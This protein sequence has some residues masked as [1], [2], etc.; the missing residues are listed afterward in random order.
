MQWNRDENGNPVSW[1]IPLETQQISPTHGV[2]QLVQVPDQHYRMTIVTEDNMQLTEVFNVQDIVE[3]SFYVDYGVGIVQFHKSQHGKMVKA[4]YYGRGVILI[5]D[6]RIFHRDGE[7]VTDTWDNILDR[8]QDALDLI[9]SAGGLVQALEKID[10]KIEQGEATAD[11]I[12]N[13]ITETQFYGYTITLS[14]EAFVVKAKEDGDV[15]KMEIQSIFTDVVVYKGAKQIIPVLSIEQENGCVFKIDGQ[16]VKLSSID[17]NVIKAGAVLN[18]DCGDGLVAKRVL[19]VTKVFDGVSQYAIDMSNAFYSFE[20]NNAGEIT[21]SQSVTCAITVTKA[22][23]DYTNYKLGVQNAPVG[24]KYTIGATGVEFCVDKGAT[25]PSSGSCL[26]VVL[27]DGTSFTKTFS[28]TKTK[29]GQDAKSLTLIGN[30]IVRYDTPDYSDI[31]SPYRSTITA[32][33]VGL[34]GTPKW[35]VKRESGWVLLEGE[36]QTELQIV[37]N[38]ERVWGNHKETTVKCSLEDYEDELTLVKLATGGNG[39]DAIT[40]ILTNESHTLAIDNSGVVHQSEIDRT[41][42]YVLAYKGAQQVAPVLT[43]GVCD[44]CDIEITD[45][46]VQLVSLDNSATTA[47]AIINVAVDGIIVPKTWSLAKAKQGHDGADGES[48]N[49]YILNVTEGTRSF[50]YSQVNLDPRPAISSTFVATLYENGAEVIEDVSYYWTARGHLQGSSVTKTF[51]PTITRTFDESIT[52]NDIQLIATYK[53]NTITQLVPIAVTKDASGLDWVQEWDSTKTDVRGNLILTP[54]IFAGAYD[55]ENDLITG[56]AI[57]QDVLND[58]RSIGVVGYQSNKPSFVLD[59]DGSLMVGNPFEKD[60]TGLYYDNGELIAK[61]HSLTIQGAEVPTTDAITS[62]VDEKLNS[63]KEG[64]LQE[65]EDVVGQVGELGAYMDGALKDGILDEVER[66]RLNTLFDN[67]GLEVNDVDAQFVSISQNP[68]LTNVAL[69][70]QLTEAY[71]A[72]TNKYEEMEVAFN[73]IIGSSTVDVEKV[74]TFNVLMEEFVELGK[75]LR[76]IM[77]DALSS[78]STSISE[79]IAEQA[80]E[81]I[82]S[83]ISDV[84]DALGSLEDTMNGDFKSGLISTMN[85]TTLRSKVSQLETEK[86]DIDGQYRGIVN[87]PKLG[88]VSRT[89]L[90]N[91]KGELDTAHDQLIIKINTAIADNLMTEAELTEINTLITKYATALNKYSEI[92]QQANAD[93]ALNLAQGA[94]AALNQEDVF[95]KLTNNGET[96]GIYLQDGK[97][98]INGEYIN[99]RNFKAVR[100]DGTQTMKIDS[101]GNVH[102]KA[103]SFHLIGDDTNVS[104]KEYVD[105]EIGKIALGNV[106]IVLSNEAQVISTNANSVPLAN[107]SFAIKVQMYKGTSEVTDFSIGTVAS[108]NGITSTV[109]QSTKTVTFSVSSTT[110]IS[111][112]SGKIT[113]PLTYEGKTYNKDWSWAIAKQ[114]A[115]GATG[116]AGTS[117]KSVDIVASSMV[118]KSADGGTTFSPNAITLTPKLQNLTYS[119]W[120]YSTNGGTS[121]STVSSGSNGLTISGGVLTISKDSSLYT[122]S[123]TSVSFRVN[124]N[125]SAYYDVV[126]IVKLYDVAELEVTAVNRALGTGT[127]ATWNITSGTNKTWTP[128]T[129]A[130]NVRSK[131]VIVAFDYEATNIVKNADYETQFQAYYV[132]S[133]GSNVYAPSYKFVLPDGDSSGTIV[134]SVLNFG[135]IKVGNKPQFRFRFDNVAGTFKISKARVIIGSRDTGWSLAPE[136]VEASISDVSNALSSFENTVNGSFKDGIIEEAEAKAISQN[137]NILNNEKADID[138]EYSSIYDNANLTGTPKTNLNSAY[139]SFISAHSSLIS[140]INTAIFDGKTTAAEKASVNSTFTTYKGVLATYKQRVQEALDAI[141]SKK[142]ENVQVGGRNL[143][144]KGSVAR[145]SASSTNTTITDEDFVKNGSV[146]I[147]RTAVTN[148]GAMIDRYVV[149]EAGKEYC[150]SYKMKTISGAINSV[151]IYNGAGHKNGKVYIDGVYKG[152]TGVDLTYPSDT[153]YHNILI[154]FTAVAVSESTANGQNTTHIIPQPI[155]STASAYT[156]QYLNLK[157]EQGNKPT[158]W[159]P[160]PEDVSQEIADKVEDY[161][162]SLNQLKVF[163]KL[164]NNGQTQGVYLENG[165]V[166]INGEYIKASSISGNKISAGVIT[167]KNGKSSINLDNGAMSLGSTSDTSYLQWTGSDL[168]IKAKNISIGSSSVATSSDVTS[169]VNTAVNNIQVGGTNLA[170]DTNKGATGWGWGIQTNNGKTITGETINGVNCVKFTKD[171]TSGSGWNYVNYGRFKRDK[172]TPSTTYVVSFEMKSN[173]SFNVGSVNLMNGDS[174]NSLVKTIT[175]I[176]NKVVANSTTWNKIIFELT[177]TDTLSTSTAQVIYITGIPCS[178]NATHY[179]RNLKLEVGNKATQWSPAPEDIDSS[180]QGAITTSKEYTNSQIKSTKDAIELSV[181]NTYETKTNVS[182]QISSTL[183]SAKSYADTK[184]S[185]AI[186]T[187]SSDATS[188]ANSALSSAKSYTDTAKNDLNTAIGKKANSADVYTKTEVYTKSQTDSAIK[189]AKDAIDLSVKS[190]DTKVTNITNTVNNIQIGTENLLQNSN[191]YNSLSNWTTQTYGTAGTDLSVTIV[192]GG[193]WTDSNYNHVQIRGTNHVD[194]Y[195]IHSSAFKVVKGQKYTVSG[196]AAG[197]RVGKIRVTI[198]KSSDGV[199]VHNYEIPVVTGGNSIDK[200]KYFTTT[201]TA[202][203]DTDTILFCFYGENLQDNGYVWGTLFK[204]E[205]GTKA[206]DWTQSSKDITTDITKAKNDAIASANGTLTT[207]IKNYYTKTETDSQIKIAKDSINLGVSQTYET[208]TNVSSQINNTLSSAKSYADTK[209]SEAISSASSDATTK[210]NNALS[211]AK[212]YADTKKTEAI[213][214]ANNTLNTTIAN[215]YTKSQTDSQINV[216]KN[217]ITQSVSNTYETKTNV[218]NKIDAIKIGG[219]NLLGGTGTAKVRNVD[220]PT[221]YDVYDTYFTDGNKTTLRALGFKVNDELSVSFDWKISKNGSLNMVYGN[222]R[223]ELMG[224]NSSNTDG[225]Y[226]GLIKNPVA[227]FSSSNTSGRFEGT[228]KLTE[229]MLGAYCLRIRTDNSVL[230]ITI[231]NAK[232]EKGNKVSS[233]S[234]SPK[235]METTVSNL[236]QRVSTAESKI[237]DTAITNVVKQNFYTKTE[238]DNQIT[239]KGYQT[240]SQVQQTVNNLQLKFTQSGGYNLFSNSGFKKGTSYWSTHTHNSPTGGSIETL[241]SSATWGFPDSTVNCV[242]IKLSNQS[243]KEYG[244]TQT[245]KTTIGKKYTLSFYYAGHRLNQ[246]NAI[247]RNSN[248]SWLANKYVNTLP[249]G[250]NTNV[251]NWN[252]YTLTFTANATSHNINIV[253]VSAANDGYLWVAK[254]MVVEGELDLPYSPNPNE[255]YDGI[256][257]MNRDGI[258]VSTSNGGWTDFTSAGMNVYNKAGNLSLGTRNGGLTYHNKKGYIGFTSESVVNAYDVAGVTISTA[259]NG[260][261]IT[262]GTSTTTDPF[263]GFT[264]TP[265]LSI[266]KADIGDANTSFYHQGV[267]LHTT[268]NVNTKPIKQVGTMYYGINGMTRTYESTTGNLCLLGDNG[269]V[270]GYYQGNDI[271]TKFKIIEGSSASESYIDTYAHWRFHGW[272][273]T[274]VANLSIKNNIKMETTATIQFN[275]T[276]TYP[277]LMW[278]A[279]NRL[280]LYGN[281]GIDFGY[282]NGSSNMPIFKLHE[283]ADTA[284][285]IESFSHWNFNNWNLENV[286]ILKPQRLQLP[287]TYGSN[288]IGLGTGDGNDY[289]TYNVKFR[290]HNGLAFTDNSDSATVIVQ[291]RQGR[292]MGK[293]AYYVNCSRSLKSD[294]RSV[295]SE[296]DVTTFVAKEGESLDTNISAETVC[297]FLDAIGVKT[298]VTDFKQEGAT[299]ECFDIEKGNSL[300]LGYVADDIAD[301]PMFKYVGEKTNDGLYAINSNSLT[302]TLIVG[303]QQEKRKREQLEERLARLEQ[304]LK[305]DE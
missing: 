94:I 51:T 193:D 200:Y 301:H 174:S 187:A 78:I 16:R 264:S 162:N 64:L 248:G 55:A 125:D 163:N 36:H 175:A 204:I 167:A 179:I 218:Q 103:N 73:E 305:G 59:T 46:F 267:N 116:S 152:T 257:E 124:T 223:A 5:S 29:R 286:G 202:P 150:I 87:N 81:E 278:E 297:D 198:R 143:A 282:R 138:K 273:L 12:E 92:A 135:D 62:V 303:Y 85:L 281:D 232:W 272:S 265:A 171:S 8:S 250:G 107:Q 195:G 155:K 86:A 288:W 74:G 108:A 210:A 159:S 247:V 72:Y 192:K 67:I 220:K 246:I 112:V 158:G 235:D 304:L 133:S 169:T 280:K 44:G 28:W 120:Q 180:V 11:R 37:H 91:A 188:K 256:V 205:K 276:A 266:A 217:A 201:F 24:L 140:T 65:F 18:I 22:N 54:K 84:S 111:A 160:A 189:V 275:S 57:G 148:E 79:Q 285:R 136:D 97:V 230:T 259:N 4:N 69:F 47:T 115:T 27:I 128:Y 294:I 126:T 245:V 271:V 178:A 186:S 58:G 254:P 225:Q 226:V 6:S 130:E 134:S 23:V 229:A 242:Q 109:A 287:S 289:T 39:A 203:A 194:R 42:T 227:N 7:N 258:K 19:E 208:K 216:A 214:S 66:N 221:S 105:G 234:P 157:I 149:Y 50:T 165:K 77:T 53:G 263:G 75:T 106:N 296:D 26:V 300:T 236:T 100:N 211:S 239:S 166:Y 172:I 260:S 228:I 76:Q 237:T 206:T 56:V 182:S 96:Q 144:K 183:T 191:F 110:A 45:N 68:H 209:K 131:K 283:G 269:V 123:V 290:T 212:S 83:E 114:G 104:T 146:T 93:I 274:D 145:Y 164:T 284:Y 35:Y 119:N 231:S 32:K 219:T 117:A 82:R 99:S 240:A 243:G 181:S 34:S 222:F 60:S 101:E 268:L 9:E 252:K 262:L 137:I 199:H 121:W 238:T 244:I 98:Y 141:S 207:T 71:D 298:Y 270:L 279:S 147:S 215:Y 31:P 25:L 70:N 1:H 2:I 48:G 184:K 63:V 233:W 90:A 173:L 154:T 156:V 293:N 132:N 151:H 302:T 213:N 295:I 30:Q 10:Q 89:N 33:M 43:K 17:I 161:D 190:V 142:V 176:Q 13:F 80:K 118:F 113:I 38:D 139:T 102:I 224:F 253:I 61:V 261:Y 122:S 129:I 299:Q 153:N 95:N 41:G 21:E 197:H 168:N 40:V 292:I 88:T 196:Y 170:Y 20:A 15:S 49:S 185:E 3:N 241:T 251:G 14:R 177:T 255:M 127:S 291:G 249:S 277:S 52:N